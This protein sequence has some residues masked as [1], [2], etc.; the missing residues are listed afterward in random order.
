MTEAQVTMKVEINF[1]GE[2]ERITK[3]RNSSRNR[4]KARQPTWFKIL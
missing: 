3:R 4:V 2:R 1:N